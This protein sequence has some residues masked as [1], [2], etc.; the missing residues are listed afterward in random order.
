MCCNVE[1]ESD[2]CLSCDLKPQFIALPEVTAPE[3]PSCAFFLPS[4][5]DPVDTQLTLEDSVTFGGIN[6]N[7]FLPFCDYQSISKLRKGKCVLCISNCIHAP[8][9]LEQTTCVN[10]LPG[11]QCKLVAKLAAS[12]HQLR[13]L[14][15][16]CIWL[17]GKCKKF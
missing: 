15:A 10:V 1:L 8:T 13:C 14:A 6:Q 12:L 7:Q 2:S 5:V 16:Y 3:L 4:F 9:F 17:L 11:C